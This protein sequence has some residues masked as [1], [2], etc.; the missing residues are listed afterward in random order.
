MAQPSGPSRFNFIGKDGGL[1]FPASP[2]HL[3]RTP[4]CAM[5]DMLWCEKETCLLFLEVKIS[6]SLHGAAL[7]ADV[8]VQLQ[9]SL[10]F[11]N[12]AIGLRSLPEGTSTIV[13]GE[14]WLPY[15]A[16]FG[17]ILL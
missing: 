10:Q 6:T 7:N 15:T 13:V 3:F 12:P 2:S 9:R 11:W 17:T 1:R 5:S 4:L 16:M 8:T 14:K